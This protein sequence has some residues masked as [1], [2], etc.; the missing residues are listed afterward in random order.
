MS[1]SLGNVLEPNEVIERFGPDALRFYC[2]R[3]V[4]FGQ[5]GSVSAAGFESRYETELAN[6]WGNLA[7][8][9]LA[10]IERFRDGVVPEAELDHALVEGADGLAG[11]DELVRDLLDA[12]ELTQALEAIWVRVRRLNRYVEE[13][14][15]WDLAKDESQSGRL[16][17]VLYNLAEGVRVLALLLVAYMPATSGA[18]LDALGEQGR[19]LDRFGGRG[20]GSRTERIAPLFPK[21]D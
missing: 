19:D 6:D 15:P 5:D 1:K 12:V 2:M 3:E 4:S 18:A 13:S 10:M 20:G 14:R 16:D 17:Q 8:R 9:T 21:L 11:I 7:S